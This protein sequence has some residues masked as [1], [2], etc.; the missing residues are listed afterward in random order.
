[1]RGTGRPAA[2][3]EVPVGTDPRTVAFT[4]NGALL[5]VAAYGSGTVAFVSVAT[6]QVQAQVAVGSRPYGVVA[7]TR[8][9][10]VSLA[11][12]PEIVVLDTAT[13]AVLSRIPVADFPAGLALSRDQAS[14]WVSHLYT[15]TV[16]AIDLATSKVRQVI[17]G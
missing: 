2:G 8:R 7:G 6:G 1:M 9:A 17:A 12:R 13:Q 4:P 11:G 15:G 3:R 5:L 14:L 10:Y 16:T